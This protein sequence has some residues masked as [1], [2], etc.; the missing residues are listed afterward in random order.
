MAAS[1]TGA[2]R[3]PKPES[4]PKLLDGMH[5]SS[6]GEHFRAPPSE[7]AAVTHACGHSACGKCD[8]GLQASEKPFC[9]VCFVAVG[10]GTVNLGLSTLSES[11]FVGCTSERC[12]AAKAAAPAPVYCAECVKDDPDDKTLAVETCADCG[13]KAFCEDDANKHRKKSKHVL[14]PIADAALGSGGHA[15][16]SANCSK[17][18][19]NPVEL[20]CVTDKVPVCAR[21]VLERHPPTTH[22]VRDLAAVAADLLD[23]LKANA[24]KCADGVAAT[25]QAVSAVDDALASLNSR[26]DSSCIAFSACIER[27]KSAL[28]TH[29][30]DKLKEARQLHH[31]RVKALEAQRTVLLIAHGQLGAVAGIAEAALASGDALM[32]A[33]AVESLNG[34]SGM[35]REPFKGPC[36]S[37]V[38]DIVSQMEQLIDGM[39]ART[40]V[41]GSVLDASKCVVSGA[42]LER[43]ALGS[44]DGALSNNVLAVA[45]FT[46]NGEAAVDAAPDDV[47]VTVRGVEDDGKAVAGGGAGREMAVDKGSVGAVVGAV[48]RAVKQASGGVI[49]VVYTVNEEYTGDEVVIDVVLTGSS[50]QHVAGS[51][52]R[53][54]CPPAVQPPITCKAQG[55]Y[56]RT[57]PVIASMS[58]YGMAVSPNEKWLAVADLAGHAVTVYDSKT[59]AVART[60]GGRG[61]D[62]CQFSSPFKIGFVPNGNLLVCDQGNHRVQELS[63]RGAH[64]RSIPV[65]GVRAV[66]SDGIVV[67][68][69]NCRGTSGQNAVEVYD[70]KTSALLRGFAPFGTAGEE[71]ITGTYPGGIR[72]TPDGKHVLFCEYSTPRLSLFTLEGKFIKHIGAG[73]VGT[74]HKD[75]EFTSSGEIIVADSSNHRVCVFSADGS[76]LLRSWGTNGTGDGQFSGP[77]ALA[78]RGPRLYVLD[79]SSPRV[80]VFE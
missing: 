46:D 26:F 77:V 22:N 7:L 37:L 47:Q 48:K 39:D 61:S 52:F 18:A 67:V 17:H 38:V 58:K 59:G 21:C 15:G 80:Q 20:Y 65:Q 6:C 24:A 9:A 71:G 42:G 10:P 35:V 75:V 60:I 73:V 34:M 64:I 30:E 68:V 55:V 53:V 19:G 50:G 2:A 13:G 45:C 72:I 44:A 1:F 49:E 51:P 62:P 28:D 78:V 54:A 25:A 63:V 69:E 76:T 16:I 41:C 4:S 14:A 3:A 33:R 29:R 8:S 11:R 40:R 74:S 12:V 23:S 70:Y 5:C 56:G 43:C 79:L 31:Q 66:C 27:V 57:I 36:V 32:T